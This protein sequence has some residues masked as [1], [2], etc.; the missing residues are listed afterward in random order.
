MKKLVLIAAVV[1]VGAA[2]AAQTPPSPAKPA[3]ARPAPPSPAAQATARQAGAVAAAAVPNPA[4]AAKHKAW[5]TQYCVACHNQRTP[6][7]AND[8]LKLDTANLDNVLADAATWERVL[9]KLSVRAMPPQ[10][11]PH[12][13]EPEYVAF[14]TWLSSSL[15]RGW[16][17]RSTPG[18]Y[19]VHRL[20]RAEY[21]NAIR[22]LL[23]IDV[24]VS[25]VLPNDGGDFGFDNIAAAL[26]TSPLLLDGY[27]TA[28]GNDEISLFL[29]EKEAK[30]DVFAYCFNTSVLF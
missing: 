9:R 2:L 13:T 20:N 22:D 6:L 28:N 15:D 16:A 3:T 5:V 7:P 11:S 12:P 8:P 18:R 21:R 23:A 26:T 4:E 27:V 19:V 25:S 24:D 1:W 17:T 14:T 30:H 29:D 10:G